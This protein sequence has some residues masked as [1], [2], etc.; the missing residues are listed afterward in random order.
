ML[1]DKGITYFDKYKNTGSVTALAQAINVFE[2]TDYYF[3]K[4]KEAQADIQSRLFWKSNNRRLYEK[5]IEACFEIQNHD[6]AFY[7]FEKSRAVLLND[8]IYEKRWMANAEIEKLSILKKD[9]L[10]LGKKM[11]SLNT[12]SNEYLE[13]QKKLVIKN[14]QSDAIVNGIKRKNPMYFK[15]YLDTS[16]INLDHLR[17]D[18]LGNSKTLMEIFAGDSA[19]YILTVTP[20]KQALAKKAKK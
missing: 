16:F 18:I 3:N 11:R 14:Q 20:D 6:K 12:D 8:Q 1:I 2:T 4:I 17:R 9:I 5:A 19:V 7:F 10:R 15:N 13:S